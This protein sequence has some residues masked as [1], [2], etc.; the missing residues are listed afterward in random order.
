MK[1]KYTYLFLIFCLQFSLAQTDFPTLEFGFNTVIDNTF[2]PDLPSS[3]Y[4][5]DLDGDGDM[6]VLSSSRNDDRIAWYENLDGLG[7]Y[8]KLK[9]ISGTADR[10]QAVYAADIDGDGDM[11]VISAADFQNEIAWYENMDGMGTFGAKNI[12]YDLQFDQSY[13]SEILAKDMDNDGDMDIISSGDDG[14]AWYENIDGQGTFDII[15]ISATNPLIDAFSLAVEDLDN[16]GDYDIVTASSFFGSPKVVYY[17]NLDG[18]GDFSSE[19]IISNSLNDFIEVI[20]ADIDSDGFMDVVFS[21]TDDGTLHWSRNMDGLGSFGPQQLI[22]SNFS[23][24][25]LGKIYAEDIDEDGFIDVVSTVT[26]GTVVWY[27]NTDGQGTF[28]SPQTL[29]NGSASSI[30][31]SDLNGDTHLDVIIAQVSNRK[32]F[33]LPSFNG[34]G[35]FNPPQTLTYSALEP[36]VAYAAD[37][38]GDNDLDVVSASRLDKKISWY[39]NIDGNG[40]FALPEEIYTFDTNGPITT[41]FVNDFDNNGAPDIIAS[42]DSGE[43]VLL[44]NFGQA[45]FPSADPITGSSFQDRT[46]FS[47]DIDNDGLNDIISITEDTVSWFKLSFSGFG[48]EQIITNSFFQS[49]LLFCADIDGDNDQDIV[50]GS[51]IG[52]RVSWFE[53]LNGQGQFSSEQLISNAID[54]PESLVVSDINGDDFLDVVV[55]SSEENRIF[56]IKNSDGL[57]NFNAPLTVFQN[58]FGVKSLEVSD[59]DNDG[60]M[61]IISSTRFGTKE[62]QWYENLDS[63]GSFGTPESIITVEK[64]IT[65]IKSYDMNSDGLQDILFASNEANSISWVNN[66]GKRNVINGN[67]TMDIDANGCDATD[68]PLENFMI[69]AESTTDTFATLTQ[70]NGFYEMTT[71]EGDFNV[72]VD[73]SLA[74]YLSVNPQSV[75]INFSELGNTS[76]SNNFCLEATQNI[77]D[78]SITVLPV[79]EA[80]PGFD[81]SYQIIYKNNGTSIADGTMTFLFDDAMMS[82]LFTDYYTINETSNELSFEF[83]DLNP[84]E[85][86]SI[87]L[88]FNVFQPPIVNGDDI[89]EIIAE[90]FPNEND[91]TP[92]NNTFNLNQVVVNSFDPNDK[93]VLQGSSIFLDEISNYLDYIV[94]FQNTGTASAI[95]VRIED[96]LDSK[97][98]WRTLQIMSS[99]HN[100]RVQITNGNFVEFIFDDIDLPSQSVSEE[101]SQGYIAFRIKPLPD[102]EAGDIISGTAD[103]F[104]DFNAPIT[105]NTVNTQI[106]EPLSVADEELQN[107]RLYPNPVSD[108]LKIT[109]IQPIN[110]LRIIDMNGRELNAIEVLANNYSMDVSSLSKGIYFLEIQSGELKSTQKFIK[111]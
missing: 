88:E 41:A 15:D 14:L 103:I 26:N 95:T 87:F 18:L 58:P 101:Q 4:S 35:I 64:D 30:Y 31:M 78:L 53:N 19:N 32:I 1:K 23:S 12:I 28:A 9:I 92:M 37:L 80:R 52:D 84:F 20:V 2:F 56:W 96:I 69:V 102:V 73:Q 62:L 68:L 34:Q 57:G 49:S 105:T 16:D 98:D 81:T 94:R 24:G 67:L 50:V 27:R 106:V 6:D 83:F 54:S 97:L 5:A 38:D 74:S 89:I 3:V 46:L 11:D 10:A 85:T 75:T 21:S 107:V 93:L 90:I 66:K 86:R 77:E 7:T 70:A 8:G 59:M 22:T 79:D 44:P 17:E 82:Y 13:D 63:N 60:D 99:S 42:G 47:V 104:F 55:A 43:L 65:F 111:N 48:N 71:L 109:S 72:E 100:Y 29:F 76:S 33:W 39:E 91:F 36:T 108:R 110:N 61:D 45:D 25:V 40:T 51:A